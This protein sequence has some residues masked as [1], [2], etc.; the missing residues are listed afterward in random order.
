[1][2]R[3]E[4]AAKHKRLMQAKELELEQWKNGGKSKPASAGIATRQAREVES[5]RLVLQ[6]ERA[7]WE[8]EREQL[9]QAAVEEEKTRLAESDGSRKKWEAELANLRKQLE[10]SKA[11]TKA[12]EAAKEKREVE[13]AAETLAKTQ[14]VE[15]ETQKV[16]EE[17]A[18]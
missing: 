4:D 16:V 9:E 1:M 6:R 12:A 14:R 11:E 7:T 2:A 10:E 13:V 17:V 8:K 15:A 5:A 3:R 18:A